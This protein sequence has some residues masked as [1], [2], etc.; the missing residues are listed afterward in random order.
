MLVFDVEVEVESR[1]ASDFIYSIY[2]AG[3]DVSLVEMRKGVG[4]NRY[5]LYFCTDMERK[6]K[7]DWKSTGADRAKCIYGTTRH[8]IP[9]SI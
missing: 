9:T 8:G 2:F 6:R 3:M 5:M 4:C 7:I 1:G